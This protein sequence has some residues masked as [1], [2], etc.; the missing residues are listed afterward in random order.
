[1]CGECDASGA[2]GTALKESPERGRMPCEIII[3]NDSRQMLRKRP[4]I[5]PRR[6]T[7]TSTY[8]GIHS[9]VVSLPAQLQ[10]STYTDILV[11]F[12]ATA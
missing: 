6:T 2:T 7:Q 1:M 3:N 11:K 9:S 4:K 10:L 5:F 12:I 8:I